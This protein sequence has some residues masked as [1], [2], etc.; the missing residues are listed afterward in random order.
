M[1]GN[2]VYTILT[3]FDK[4]EQNRLRK[5]LQ[6]P[7]FNKSEELI[8]LFE[9][10]IK[11]INQKKGK[12]LTSS[13]LDKNKELTGEKIWSDLTPEKV[14]DNV[15]YRKYCSDLLKLTEG[16]LAQQIYEENTLH[17]APYL[18]NAVGNK[19]MLKLYN[20]TLKTARRISEQ[21][22]YKPADFF[23]YQFQ[24]EKNFYEM[25]TSSK[26]KRVSRL[27]VEEIVNNLDYY[28]LAEKLRYYCLV[29]MQRGLVSH[30]YELLFIDEIIDHIEK[31]IL[32]Y[33]KIP[34]IAVYFSV[35]KTLADSDNDEHYINLIDLMER[36]ENQFPIGETSGIYEN[37][38][39]YCVRKLNSGSDFHL[40]EYLRLFKTLLKKEILIAE[41]ELAPHHFN[42]TIVIAMR[43]GEYSWTEQFIK[44][45]QFKLDENIRENLVIYN[46]ALVYFY[47][48]KY[49]QVISLLQEVEYLEVYYYLRSKSLQLATYYELNEIDPLF[50]LIDSL[51][52]YMNRHKSIAKEK[53]VL[54]EN[55][56]KFTKKLV[57]IIPGDKKAIAKLRTEVEATKGIASENWL[58]E[59]IAELEK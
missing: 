1:T 19:R 42:N 56:I 10:L 34:P 46:L 2:K 11:D 23:Y 18:L 20:S 14:F 17:Q 54:Y 48:K 33:E 21:Q 44:Q 26:H 36:Y 6:S 9:I 38:L 4:Y 37:A 16:F 15:R 13:K 52:T 27:N 3:F 45:Y 39:N 30:E 53:K 28:Y 7:Y 50:S 47:Q 32:E 29:L 31:Y 41:G 51:R 5:Y 59:K 8:N 35:Y 24:I 25:T 43:L 22:Q 40:K 57:K 55:L 58:K 49:D 12:D